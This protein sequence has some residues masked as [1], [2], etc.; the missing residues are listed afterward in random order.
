MQYGVWDSEKS[1]VT[2]VIQG[3]KHGDDDNLPGGTTCEQA[4]L[5][6]GAGGLK[7][8]IVKYL[9]DVTELTLVSSANRVSQLGASTKQI[10]DASKSPGPYTY[11]EQSQFFGF[12]STSVLNDAN[13]ILLAAIQ[14]INYPPACLKAQLKGLPEPEQK[15]GF[16]VYFN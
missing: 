11:S 1:E 8:L 7:T 15:T 6:S 13:Q 2:D 4:D 10:V 3:V 16:D 14:V 5:L 12:K 9:T